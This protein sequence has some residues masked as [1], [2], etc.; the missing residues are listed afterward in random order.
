MTRLPAWAQNDTARTLLRQIVANPP[1]ARVTRGSW[2]EGGGRT[3]YRAWQRPDVAALKRM[4]TAWWNANYD[5]PNRPEYEDADELIDRLLREGEQIVE[6][7]EKE[8]PNGRFQVA[9]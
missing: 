2:I 7:E 4:G 5:A 8:L 9:A 3:V 1:E 6:V